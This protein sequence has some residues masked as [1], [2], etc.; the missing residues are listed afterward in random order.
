M[1][2]TQ[3]LSEPI[4]NSQ[5]SHARARR[6][7]IIEDR[8]S[9]PSI[10]HALGY[11]SHGSNFLEAARRLQDPQARFRPNDH[12]L[13]SYFL[14]GHS[15]ELSLKSYLFAK[16]YSVAML[17][18]RPF[19]HDLES[20]LNEAT[21]RK[22]G[23]EAKLTVAQKKAISRLNTHYKSKEFE[24]LQYQTY[25]LPEYRFVFGVARTLS[26]SLHRFASRSRY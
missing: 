12:T 10:N 23:R 20:I 16:G 5:G 3:P 26:Q 13:T 21:R 2:R 7:T 1:S 24:Y 14:V 22:L 9:T 6:W 19:G 4:R 8:V 17:R 15:I 11:W 25:R 18:H